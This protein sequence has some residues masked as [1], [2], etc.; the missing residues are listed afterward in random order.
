[1][2]PH[3]INVS[4]LDKKDRTYMPGIIN[5]EA[6]TTLTAEQKQ[7]MDGIITETR[8][9]HKVHAP[10]LPASGGKGGGV[11]VMKMGDASATRG[12][13]GMR[14]ISGTRY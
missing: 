7:M 6:M 2:M 13:M 11:P 4:A 8:P 1:M 9:M 14:H 10:G 3:I 5:I 12:V